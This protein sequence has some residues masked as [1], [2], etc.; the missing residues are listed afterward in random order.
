MQT[1]RPDKCNS[2][3]SDPHDIRSRQDTDCKYPVTL[4]TQTNT[5]NHKP[6]TARVIRDDLHI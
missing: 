2:T 1:V 5:I 6:C 3:I 4:E